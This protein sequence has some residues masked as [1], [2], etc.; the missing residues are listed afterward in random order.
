MPRLSRVERSSTH[1]AILA[2][3][4]LTLG[5]C[6]GG[7]E[8]GTSAFATDDGSAETSIDGDGDGGGDGDGDG[9]GDGQIKFDLGANDA[10]ETGDGAEGGLDGCKKVDV[11]F[12]IDNSDSMQ[13]EIGAMKGPVFDELPAALLSVNGGI[14]DFQLGVVTG[15]PSPAHLHTNGASGNCGFSTGAN[16]MVSSSPAIQAEYQCVTDLVNDGWMGVSQSCTDS[17]S[18][19]DDE[20]QPA[21][22]TARAVSAPAIDGANLGFLRPDAVLF[23]VA[24]TDEDE[25]L[26]DADSAAQIRD[27]IVNA[28]GDVKNVVFLGIGGGSDCQGLYGDAMDAQNLRAVAELF[29]ADGRGVFHDLCGGNLTAGFQAA[30]E[31]VD[32][33]CSEFIPPG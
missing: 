1:V 21:L 29:A 22:T 31:I 13:E 15:C 24:I 8:S 33:A 32:S 19:A 11:V 7:R 18:N 3:V 17:G 23:L 6:Q 16:Y 26:L 10:G 27:E 20:E 4:Q 28:K 14:D 9:D 25:E 12:A 2:G 30:L 5:A